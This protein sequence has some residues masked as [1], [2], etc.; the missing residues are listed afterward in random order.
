MGFSNLLPQ[1][2]INPDAD[3]YGETCLALSRE[4]ARTTACTLDVAYGPEPEHRLDVYH[5]AGRSTAGLPVLLFLH[6]GGFTHGYKEWCGFMAPAIAPAVLVAVRYRLVPG[7]PYPAAFLD[8][9][10]ALAWCRAHVSA[11]GGDALRIFVGGHSAGGAMAATIHVRP[12]W[13]ANAALASSAISGV[14][15]LSTTFHAFAV[16]GSAGGSYASIDG[17]LPVDP[18]SPLARIDAARA[19]FFIAWG[20]RERQR[21]RV[22]RSSLAAVVALRDRRIPVEWRFLE[23]ADHFGTHLAFADARHPWSVALRAWLFGR[24]D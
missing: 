5:P 9:V 16:S 19:P 11:Y 6:G 10:A 15:C 21:E 18:E 20:G 12:D 4:V 2:P 7:A 17:P 8:A 14:V 1:T 22:E 13:L 24:T 3:R 23:D